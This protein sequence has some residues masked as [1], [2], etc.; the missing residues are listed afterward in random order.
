MTNYIWLKLSTTQE[1]AKT[2]PTAEQIRNYCSRVD[3]P[4]AKMACFMIVM[5]SLQV[6]RTENTTL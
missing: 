1:H 5:I 4:I 3:V 2:L 6:F